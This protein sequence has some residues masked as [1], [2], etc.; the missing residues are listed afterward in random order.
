MT[1]SDLHALAK[2]KVPYLIL[3]T[4]LMQD[5]GVSTEVKHNEELQDTV[6]AY[7]REKQYIYLH[8]FDDPNLIAGYGR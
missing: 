5:F 8:P 1:V 6:D 4:K 2:V 3:I 7:V